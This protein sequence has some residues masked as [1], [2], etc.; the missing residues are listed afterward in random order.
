MIAFSFERMP[1][2]HLCFISNISSVR[3]KQREVTSY[4][5]SKILFLQKAFGIKRPETVK[6]CSLLNIL[7]NFMT[8]ETLTEAIWGA[9]F[10]IRG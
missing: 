10:E 2:I 8:H 3:T 9:F 7:F 6:K 4:G 5:R 1:Y